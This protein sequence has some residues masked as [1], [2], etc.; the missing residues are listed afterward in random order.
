MRWAHTLF[1]LV[2]M[3]SSYILPKRFPLI[4]QVPYVLSLE[5][6]YDV[7]LLPIEEIKDGS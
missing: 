7:S 2:L 1:N 4:F 6:R 3:L 5:Q